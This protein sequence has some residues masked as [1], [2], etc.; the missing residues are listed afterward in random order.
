MSIYKS[1]NHSNPKIRSLLK[2]ILKLHPEEINLSLNRI[3]VLLNKLNNPHKKLPRAIHIAGTNGKGSVATSLYQLQKLNG[4]KVHVYRSPHLITFNERIIVA[5]KKIDD[6]LFYH[7]LKHV[8]N[9]NKDNIITFFEFL[10][11][12][13][14]Y[15]FSNFKADLLVC[16]VG[17]GGK[18]DATN[19]L[20]GK[21]KICI[22]T[23]IGLDHKEFLGNSL[24]KIA[25]EKLGILKK[26]S[27]LISTSQNKK[28]YEEVFLESIKKNCKTFLYGKDWYIR[29]KYF[30]LENKKKI[31]LENLSLEGR[32][33]YKNVGCAIV[34]CS[35]IKNLYIEKDKILKFIKNLEWQ[36]RLQKLN[37]SISKKHPNIEFW[38][39]CAHNPLGFMALRTWVLKKN[40]SNLIIIL[41]VGIAKD[42][43]G[44]LKQI[45]KM[46]PNS[47]ILLNKTNF[48]SRPAKELYIEAKKL[49]LNCNLLGD[50]Y[51][52]IN[53]FSKK[54]YQTTKAV[55]LLAGSINLVGEVI[56]LDNNET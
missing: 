15:I 33:Q 31:S 13:A 39:D 22:I 10:T 8:Y 23:T 20:N 56:K 11:A 36:G 32:H 3:K 30:Y 29:N 27:I 38:A 46:K 53:I 51:D 43:K 12:T 18:Y 37:G 6:D 17:L 34:A 50:I 26:K 52:A 44:I 41:G 24:K 48:N 40:I 45:K 19:V 35:K 2:S 25:K 21:N 55:C 5:N 42:Y 54:K 7:S 28:V 16:E 49:K 9:I 1:I 4:K 47:L 14:F